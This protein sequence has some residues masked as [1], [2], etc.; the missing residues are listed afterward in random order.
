MSLLTPQ[1]KKKSY[2]NVRTKPTIA[3]VVTVPEGTPESEKREYKTQDGDTG[4]KYEL[5]YKEING[6]VKNISLYEGK[7]GE[8]LHIEILNN[9]DKTECVLSLGVGTSYG[10]FVMKRLLNLDFNEPVKFSSYQDFTSKEGKEV[11]GGINVY[12]NGVKIENY[13]WDKEKKKPLHG[14][15]EP[16][17]D[18]DD[19]ATE[20]W[21]IFFLQA[22]KFLVGETK[23]LIA[24]KFIADKFP[25]QGEEKVEYPDEDSANAGAGAF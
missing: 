3:Y 8:N 13:Y 5:A 21:K 12:Q 22:R 2:I 4:V 24:E 10:E 20:D 17:G 25:E 9:E 23:K 6:V 14:Y 16:Q 18:T 11:S 1:E 15:P 7:W 19:Y